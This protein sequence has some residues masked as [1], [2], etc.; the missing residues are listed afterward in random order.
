[1][2]LLQYIIPQHILSRLVLKFTRLKLGGFTH[3]LIKRFI[4]LYKV[5]MNIAESPNISDYNSFNQFFTRSLKATARP[6][7]ATDIISPVDAQISQ[8]GKI[9][10]GSL[11]QAKGRYF[12]LDDLLAGQTDMVN[13]FKQ[14]L[15]TTLYLAPKDYHRIHMPITGRLKDMVYVPGRL[16][17]VNQRT[18]RA[19][20]NLFARNE[21]VICLFETELGPMAMILVG[22]LFV[23]SIDTV[24]A[25]TVAPSRLSS[26]KRWN[27]SEPVLEK[28][29]EMGRFNMGST[30]II[31]HDAQHVAWLS[32][33]KPQQNLNM[34]EGLAQAL[35]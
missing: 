29:A 16:F 18:S 21:R 14:G 28:G 13:L 32:E 23:G 35:R 9:N 3:W 4:N 10:N 24:W 34:G 1:M 33:L 25:G 26:I 7:A 6:L 22:A 31:L 2:I 17:S 20:P 12:Q 19:V 11:I 30:V 27:Y 5:N 8:I 15:F